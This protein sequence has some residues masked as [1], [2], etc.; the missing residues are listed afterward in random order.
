[1]GTNIEVKPPNRISN[2]PAI[3]SAKPIES[4]TKRDQGIFRKVED[5]IG[6]KKSFVLVSGGLNL[7]KALKILSDVTRLDRQHYV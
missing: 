6:C 1:M 7:Q 4:K 5:A 3:S 2:K